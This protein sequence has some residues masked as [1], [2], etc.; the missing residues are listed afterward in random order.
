V[1]TGQVA[2]GHVHQHRQAAHVGDHEERLGGVG[3]DFHGR[4]DV[5]R[6]DDAGERRAQQVALAAGFAGAAGGEVGQ[7]QAGALG[8]GLGLLPVGLG[9]FEL[10]AGHDFGGEQALHALE[11]GFLELGVGAGLGQVG[12]GG[13]ELGGVED[14]QHVAGLDAVAQVGADLD[15]PAGDRR[16]QPG[17]GVLVVADAGGEGLVHRHRGQLGALDLELGELR[18]GGGEAQHAG[19]GGGLLD[20]RFGGH[21]G[22]GALQVPGGA[23]EG[24]DGDEGE[25]DGGAF[26]GVSP[27]R[28]SSRPARAS[29]ARARVA[30]MR[31]LRRLR[32][33]SR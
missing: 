11:G 24:G 3:A 5:A 28:R 20:H 22:R 7:A 10:A 15:G 16:K 2:L 31:A 30:S 23:G 29:S 18:R 17:G 25:G 6:G 8:F 12:G 4:V 19:F 1:T 13:A 14:G 9:G 33:V 32:W 26:H 21:L 27:A